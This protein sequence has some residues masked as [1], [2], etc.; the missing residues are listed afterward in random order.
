MFIYSFPIHLTC[1]YFYA[2]FGYYN[3]NLQIFSLEI[4]K[5]TICS[6]IFFK[7]FEPK[8]YVL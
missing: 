2:F 3:H 7:K 6:F 5:D 4:I 1:I 8:L